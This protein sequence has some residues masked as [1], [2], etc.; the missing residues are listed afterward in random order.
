MRL[1]GE[2]R[3]IAQTDRIVLWVG[4]RF[5]DPSGKFRKPF[6]RPAKRASASSAVKKHQAGQ[7]LR[8]SGPR[9]TGRL[10]DSIS[11]ADM[12][13]FRND[14]YLAKVGCSYETKRASP[15]R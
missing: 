11:Y 13:S 1:L 6:Q 7:E 14:D 3:K 12:F 9:P 4:D 2:C 15:H 10:A 5:G 8:I